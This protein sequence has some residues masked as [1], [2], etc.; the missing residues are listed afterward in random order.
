MFKSAYTGCA[1]LLLLLFAEKS[2]TAQPAIFKQYRLLHYSSDNGLVQ[3]SINDMEMDKNGNLWLATHG[4]V[5]VFNGYQFILPLGNTSSPRIQYIVR[6]ADG[7]FYFR[8]EKNTVYNANINRLSLSPVN[9]P[10]TAGDSVIWLRHSGISAENFTN[11]PYKDIFFSEMTESTDGV[12][13]T[14]DK[15]RGGLKCF[16]RKLYMLDSTVKPAA[17]LFAY[18]DRGILVKP[19]NTIT[20]YKGHSQSGK[21]NNNLTGNPESTAYSFLS[22][23]F[24]FSDGAKTFCF[25]KQNIYQIQ[26]SGSVFFLTKWVSDIPSVNAIGRIIYDSINHQFIIGSQTTGLY[27]VQPSGFTNPVHASLP[28]ATLNSENSNS[29]Y[30]QLMMA[31]NSVLDVNWYRFRYNQPSA[32]KISDQPITSLLCKDEQGHFWY[33]DIRNTGELRECD[34]NWNILHRYTFPKHEDFLNNYWGRLGDTLYFSSDFGIYYLEQKK[35]M[36]HKI[37]TLS[38]RNRISNVYRNNEST[39]WILTNGGI[40]AFDG[41][42]QLL[43]SYPAASD[44]YYRYALKL[45]KDQTL[46]C[47]Y[48]KGIWLLQNGK[49]RQLPLDKNGYLKFAHCF[50]DDNRG[51]YWVTTNNGLFQLNKQSLFNWIAGKDENIYYHYF[52]KTYG[53][54]NNEFNGGLNASVMSPNGELLSFCNMEGLVMLQRNLL[55]NIYPD[56]PILVY[57]MQA[58]DSVIVNPEGKIAIHAGYKYLNFFVSTANYGHSQNLHLE[59]SI[60]G[61]DDAWKPV[62][63]DNIIR[64]GHI[65]HGTYTLRLRKL[66]GLEKNNYTTAEIRFSIAPKWYYQWWALVAGFFL[67]TGLI[68][69][70]AHLR[71]RNIRKKNKRLAEIITARTSE[72]QAKNQGLEQANRLNEILQSVMLHDIKGPLKSLADTAELLAEKWRQISED[73]KE[74]TVH[75]IK[76]TS[77]STYH[78][79]YHLLSWIKLRKNGGHYSEN[80]GLHNLVKEALALKQAENISNA[81]LIENKIDTDLMVNTNP[82]IL[83]I[84]LTN[85]IDNALKNTQHGKISIRAISKEDG[86]EIICTDTGRGITKDSINFLLSAENRGNDPVHKDS[87][88]LGYVIIRELLPLLNGNIRIESVIGK[89][90]MVSIFIPSLSQDMAA[91]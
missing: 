80:V 27:I 77:S 25:H 9:K 28:G 68:L 86:T 57:K 89:G 33:H 88:K 55:Q 23:S 39:F 62:N 65:G 32:T 67:I 31:D 66:A 56:N 81:L 85:I 1:V 69:I 44:Y 42:K 61:Y 3:N 72:L 10:G 7:Q 83:S 35:G 53:F 76:N 17:K 41:Y 18:Q 34:A 60:K 26:L 51:Y 4:G 2:I 36:L 64:L 30:I 15:A 45:G 19:D 70:T 90:T 47:T 46:L 75:Q 21:L 20:W 49:M 12:I 79:I 73:L 13:Y 11:H 74:K 91:T 38:K 37:A 8:D 63:S 6:N 82:Q 87:F 50:Q 43:S 29:I 84:I 24:I 22:N 16:D 5:V 14:N 71:T 58:D 48:G 78:Y 54:R 52:D 59:Y 40:I